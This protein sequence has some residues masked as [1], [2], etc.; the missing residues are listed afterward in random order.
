M[1]LQWRYFEFSQAGHRYARLLRWRWT[2]ANEFVS[3]A[4]KSI[5]ANEE[6]MKNWSELLTQEIVEPED[7][8]E[9]D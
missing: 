9:F 2:G 7:D 6:A 1:R 8:S 5:G 3:E 4:L